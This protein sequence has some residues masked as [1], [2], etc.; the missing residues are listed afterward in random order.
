MGLCHH[1]CHV[2]Q[3]GRRVG[4][5]GR[6]AVGP[7]G[8]CGQ[9]GPRAG[10]GRGAA[11]QA[12]APGLPGRWGGHGSSGPGSGGS[13]SVGRRGAPLNGRCALQRVMRSPVVQDC[14]A[15]ARSR[16]PATIARCFPTV[17]DLPVATSSLLALIDDIA[18]LLDDVALLTKVAAKKTA[19]VLGDDLALNA[20]QVAG[21]QSERELPV[22]WAVAKGSFLNKAILVPAALAI[23]AF[24]PLA[25]DAAADGRRCLPVLRRLR[26][27]GAQV[28]ATARTR[29][30]PSTRSCWLPRPTRAWTWSPSSATRSRA[31]CAPIS[32]CRPRSS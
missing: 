19:G 3:R 22:V 13:F 15:R 9:A 16:R 8:P 20:Q 18:T 32:S 7:C 30:R 23:S 10:P 4:W 12:C 26:E 5:H 1:L 29:T 2:V 27:A 11:V 17:L 25:G 31:R 6:R 21:V 14:T 28:P 24:A